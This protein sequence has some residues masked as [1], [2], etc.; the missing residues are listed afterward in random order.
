MYSNSTDS[1]DTFDIASQLPKGLQALMH[2]AQDAAQSIADAALQRRSFL[3]VATTSGFA[4][5]AFPV[6]TQAQTMATAGAPAASSLKPTQQPSAFVRID[7]D[8]TVTVTI[9]RLDFGQGVQT[10]LPMILA[11][12]LDADW[13]KVKSQHGN[14]DR[15]MWTRLSACTSRAARAPSK[16][17]TR[18]TANLARAHVPCWCRPPRRNGAW[19]RAACAPS[20]AW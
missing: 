6:L 18:S 1:A 3:K 4:L 10:G 7:K 9:N 2:K 14:A 20:R 15:P 11:E 17:L 8:G 12:E 13:A 19:M 5:G 16:T